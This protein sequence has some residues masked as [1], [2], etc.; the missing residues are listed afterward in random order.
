MQLGGAAFPAGTFQ[1]GHD[2]LLF[3]PTYAQIADETPV[4]WNVKVAPQPVRVK[5]R[6][7]AKAQPLRPQR[8]PEKRDGS[9]YGIGAGFRHRPR[10]KPST[11]HRGVVTEDRKLHG[12]FG[13]ARKLE[14]AVKP[15]PV[16]VP[17]L[18]RR[19]IA[20]PKVGKAGFARVGTV[21]PQ[22]AP[23]L[24]KTHR[25]RKRERRKALIQQNFWHRRPPKAADV[26]S[27]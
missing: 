5:D 10:T 20:F 12:R 22:N 7:P 23:R 24:A 16:A 8:K 4:P 17:A 2:V 6:D 25:R 1:F 3:R 15:G 26:A 19:R 18:Q 9:N 11:F 21:D 13:H 27:P 14:L